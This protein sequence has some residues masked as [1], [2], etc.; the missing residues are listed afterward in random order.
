MIQIHD[1]DYTFIRETLEMIRTTAAGQWPTIVARAEKGLAMLA[2]ARRG[3]PEPPTPPSPFH[4][5]VPPLHQ[6]HLSAED[7]PSIPRD[8]S[9][10]AH[11]RTDAQTHPVHDTLIGDDTVKKEDRV[12]GIMM[13]PFCICDGADTSDCPFHDPKHGEDHDPAEGMSEESVK[14]HME[15]MEQHPELYNRP[16][17]D[18]F[19]LI[20]DR[21]F[22]PQSGLPGDCTC[23]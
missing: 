20:C 5:K 11:L 15:M 9:A 19:P 22:K 10:Q 13:A 14:M 23:A 8:T 17:P 12:G 4:F 21:C 3:Y 18:A 2:L 16:V 6:T 1:S 7:M